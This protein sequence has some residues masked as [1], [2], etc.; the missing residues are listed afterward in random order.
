MAFNRV[1]LA[2]VLLSVC[3]FPFGDV[4]AQTFSTRKITDRIYVLDN[5][6]GEDQLVIASQKGLVVFNT[7]W[8]EI[9]ARKYKDA[10]RSA[11]DRDDF[12][13]TVNMVDRLDMFGGNAAFG[14]TI[15]IGH[16]HLL[17]KYK[18]KEEEVDAEIER[19]IEMWRWKEDVS[20]KRL[21]THAP[22]S[23]AERNERR[24][25][26]TCRERAD[27]LEKGFSLVLPT[28]VYDDRK[29]L[30]LEDIKLELIWFGRAGFDGMTIVVVP[31]EKV[32]II[33][34]FIMHS[35]H[36]APHPN[37]VYA[38]FDVDRWIGVLEEILEGENPVERVICDM[39]NVWPR[40][41]ARTH[42]VYIRTLWN[43]VKQAEAA[44][45]SLDEVQDALSL[46]GE[47]AFVKDMQPYKDRGD[48]WIRPQHE[49]H[50]R[51]FYLQHKNLASEILKSESE[52]SF[53]DALARIR[54]MRDTGGDI[55]FDEA[56]MNGLGYGLMNSSRVA[57]AIEV[58]KLNVER[59]PGSANT[60]DSLAEAYMKNGDT[61]KAIEH[62]R[63]SLELNPDNENAEKILKKLEAE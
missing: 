20:Q 30:D 60:Y 46:D 16:N 31:E 1:I 62:Y 4:E 55:Y 36:L 32:A 11:L 15:I 21:E 6:E 24:W 49:C 8:S 25:M 53:R 23:E 63:T 48:N 41:R 22:G 29:S 52:G 5:P 56:S 18:D 45:K 13:L 9:T 51:V 44:G 33:P 19:L 28:A 12:Y 35:H 34:G 2:C 26:N 3:A 58:L 42:L 7:L 59:F 17:E 40:E 37:C 47:F 27:E 10:I 14:E 50:V 38:R 54:R 39:S 57:D 43:D 61:E